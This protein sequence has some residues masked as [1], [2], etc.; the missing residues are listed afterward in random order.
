VPTV[1]GITNLMQ[2]QGKPKRVAVMRSAGLSVKGKAREN[3]RRP[4]RTISRV[5]TAKSRSDVRSIPI[6]SVSGEKGPVRY[7]TRYPLRSH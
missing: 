1:G 7:K 4:I 3:G 2:G 5:G 6:I